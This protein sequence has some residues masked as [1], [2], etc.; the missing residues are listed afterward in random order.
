MQ[1]ATF[2][3]T[4]VMVSRLG[5]GG[6]PIQRI[7]DDE[8]TR[9]VH[10]CLGE[11]INFFDTARGYADSET[12]L[13]RALL[14]RRHQAIVA[15]KSPG[16]DGMSMR[17]DLEACLRELQTDYLDLYQ[18]HN[19]ATPEAWETVCAE[20]GALQELI[21]AQRSGLVRF[22]GVSSHSNELLLK[23]QDTGIFDT[24]QFPYNAVEKQFVPSMERGVA[25]NLGRIVMKPLAGG[26]FADAGLA[27]RFALEA[28]VSVVIPGMDSIEQVVQ[29]VAAVNAGPLS[30]EERQAVLAEAESLGG[31]FCRRCDYCQP[32]PREVPI[33]HIY[34]LEAYVL[35]YG[36]ADWARTRY[37]ALPFDAGDC[38]ECGVCE[39]KCPYHLPLREKL[40]RAHAALKQ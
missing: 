18:L 40:K 32:C 9:L 35:R 25:L 29:N 34:I 19:V 28:P 17:R 3:R 27:I 11:G 1:Y 39:A 38:I 20:G 36:L 37:A 10:R 30:H 7:G 12:K 16:R 13:G 8:A 15:S 2:G 6:I 24:V 31:D 5:F 21:S 4:G 23:M 26:S 33:S 14:G 22:I